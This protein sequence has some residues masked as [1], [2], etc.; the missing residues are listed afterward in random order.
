MITYSAYKI[1]SLASLQ[2]IGRGSCCLH[3]LRRFLSGDPTLLERSE[4]ASEDCSNVV[5][6]PEFLTAKE[7]DNLLEEIS[8]TLRGKKYLYDHWDGVRGTMFFTGS[9]CC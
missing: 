1:C 5:V 8:R 9:G 6:I 4:A 3:I 2:S 7:G